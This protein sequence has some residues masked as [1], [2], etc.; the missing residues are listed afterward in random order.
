VPFDWE[1]QAGLVCEILCCI[2]TCPGTE[3]QR[4]DLRR[5][6]KYLR[7]PADRQN[8]Q[9]QLL[10]TQILQSSTVTINAQGRTCGVGPG[11]RQS[12]CYHQILP[13]AQPGA[14]AEPA[15]LKLMLT[16]A[17]GYQLSVTLSQYACRSLDRCTPRVLCRTG[18]RF[19]TSSPNMPEAMRTVRPRTL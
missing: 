3:F 15:C 17:A 10:N 7:V 14:S 19:G 11:T 2:C 1:A 8:R 13:D 12:L 5:S 6:Q 18:E 16:V 4:I 9:D